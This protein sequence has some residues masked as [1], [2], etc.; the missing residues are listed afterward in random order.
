M[1]QSV[2][3]NVEQI[4]MNKPKYQYPCLFCGTEN[5]ERNT[6][7]IIQKGFGSNWTLPDDVCCQCNTNLFSPL[8]KKLLDFVKNLVY[9]DHPDVQRQKTI[10]QLGY[11]LFYEE[12]T[13]IWLSI[14]IDENNQPKPILLS[15]IIFLNG[16]DSHEFRI[17]LE[18]KS[19]WQARIDQI[20]KEVSSPSSLN[21]KEQIIDG[22][23]PPVQPA[24]IRSAE[25]KYLIIAATSEDA[26]GVRQ[27]V[28]SS[29]LSRSLVSGTYNK[30]KSISSQPNVLL[31]FNYDLEA[32]ERALAKSAVNVICSLLGSEFA[33]NPMFSE[34]KSFVLG[35]TPY[36]SGKFV[37][38]WFA[39][40]NTIAKE[41]VEQEVGKPE[42]HTILL[43]T[44]DNSLIICFLFYSRLF[45]SI[46][47]TG[48]NNLLPQYKY[49]LF[50]KDIN[51]KQKTHHDVEIFDLSSTEVPP[52]RLDLS[53]I[54]GLLMEFSQISS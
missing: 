25:N 19:D 17:E 8:D 2:V 9:W 30:P 38:Y 51:Y 24:L 46:T 20:V 47:L 28:S 11:S 52:E 10:V 18:D 12:Q 26:E 3:C 35:Q 23:F 1:L 7:H 31:R 27:Q 21:L 14:R 43:Q 33:R 45:A 48:T 44:K 4:E 54:L 36:Q 39:L 53:T 49:K 15:Q 13:G 41:L 22:L 5:G 16:I 37:Q 42:C 34:I 32:I 40:N 50:V 6:E 29:N